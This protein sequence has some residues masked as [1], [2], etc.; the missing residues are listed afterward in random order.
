MVQIHVKQQQQQ[1]QGEEKQFLYECE[2][3]KEIQEIAKDVIEI[4]N[5]QSKIQYL[6]HAL[7]QRLQSQGCHPN[8]ATP[9][10]RA[11]SEAKAYASKDQALNKRPLS[12]HV[13]RDHIQT[14][15]REALVNQ[16]MGFS[17][18]N[19]LQNL[20]S[21]TPASSVPL[22]CISKNNIEL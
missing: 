18:S 6:V 22:Y 12:P 5:L 11:L 14:I 19:Q 20:F 15:E 17:D 2:C 8:A 7:Q 3:A 16:F 10:M 21:G 13:L 1:L 9:L 4:H